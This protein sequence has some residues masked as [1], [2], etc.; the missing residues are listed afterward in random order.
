MKAVR[1]KTYLSAHFGTLTQRSVHPSVPVLL[2]KDLPRNEISYDSSLHSAF[3]FRILEA[4]LQ[5]LISSYTYIIRNIPH[6]ATFSPF[7]R[8]VIQ[9]EK[10]RRVTLV[11]LAA[12]ITAAVKMQIRHHQIEW[13]TSY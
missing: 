8:V 11:N 7:F 1:G 3:I 13:V 5:G 9:L 4:S 2:T 6:C 12:N 10:M